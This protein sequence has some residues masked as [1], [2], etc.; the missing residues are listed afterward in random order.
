MKYP[1]KPHVLNKT[2]E[3]IT[4]YAGMDWLYSQLS[5]KNKQLNKKEHRIVKKWIGVTYARVRNR[6]MEKFINEHIRS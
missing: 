2:E 4:D 6:S 3:L 5:I 1:K